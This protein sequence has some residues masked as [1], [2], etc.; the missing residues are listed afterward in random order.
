MATASSSSVMDMVLVAEQRK[1]NTPLWKLRKAWGRRP[2]ELERDLVRWL[3]LLP[4]N[5]Y[6][7]QSVEVNRGKTVKILAIW[8]MLTLLSFLAVPPFYM[9]TVVSGWYSW[10][11][12]RMRW[13]VMYSDPGML[14]RNPPDRAIRCSVAVDSSN[15]KKIVKLR[16][17][18]G[19]YSWVNG[20][21]GDAELKFCQTCAIYRPPETHHCRWC[22]MCINIHDHHCEWLGCCIG[23]KNRRDFIAL[24][25]WCVLW[26]MWLMGV[27]VGGIVREAGERVGE[28][29]GAREEKKDKTVD[30][31]TMMLTKSILIPAI[32]LLIVAS[33]SKVIGI[34]FFAALRE[35]RQNEKNIRARMEGLEG[36]RG[37][38]APQQLGVAEVFALVLRGRAMA[39]A[40]EGLCYTISS[41]LQKFF[42]GA[43]VL[44]LFIIAGREMEGGG[45]EGGVV[46]VAVNWVLLVLAVPLLLFGI[47]F[48]GGT[49][50][51]FMNGETSRGVVKRKRASFERRA[52]R[53]RLRGHGAGFVKLSTEEEEEEEGWVGAVG[54]SKVGREGA[55]EKRQGIGAFQ[56]LRFIV[57]PNKTG[58]LPNEGEERHVSFERLCGTLPKEVDVVDMTGLECIANCYRWK[59]EGA[60]ENAAMAHFEIGEKEEEDTQQ[61]GHSVGVNNVIIGIVDV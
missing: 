53:D 57:N 22:D 54:E 47:V 34:P 45:D 7:V 49:I 59:E 4:G 52:K 11:M 48:T 14:L 39:S 12:F 19:E 25:L 60:E 51:T 55:E 6:K 37:T 17:L 15:A 33:A 58:F 21:G 31:T 27:G 56:F 38:V 36:L 18:G 23:V 61:G 9:A 32:I 44:Y 1:R 13:I 3:F 8:V 41:G 40:R 50:R 20:G 42:V 16:D 30:G 28:G 24:L 46:L 43:I 29:G 35:R 10:W 26:F 5:A 2:V